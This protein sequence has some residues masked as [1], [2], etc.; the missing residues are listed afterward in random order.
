VFEFLVAVVAVR[1]IVSSIAQYS[2]N[3]FCHYWRS[4]HCHSVYLTGAAGRSRRSACFVSE[5]TERF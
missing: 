3:Y 2:R 5:T 1:M 4:R